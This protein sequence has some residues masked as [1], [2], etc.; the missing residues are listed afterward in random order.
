ERDS[1]NVYG[2]DPARSAQ[3]PARILV[4]RR[5]SKPAVAMAVVSRGRSSRT[6]AKR[7]HSL[8][9]AKAPLACLLVR[10]K[11]HIE[12][13]YRQ[14]LRRPLRRCFSH[15]GRPVEGLVSACNRVDGVS[16]R[17][18]HSSWNV[19]RTGTRRVD[20][21]TLVCARKAGKRG[22]ECSAPVDPH[23]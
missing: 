5:H 16:P 9:A 2:R 10:G 15:K 1:E 23:R 11:T 6:A 13:V 18:E 22:T 12:F 17:R 7:R 8:A 19:P 3:G 20:A 4:T 14:T 21:N